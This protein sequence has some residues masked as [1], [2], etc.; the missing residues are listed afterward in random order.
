MCAPLI[1]L[2]KKFQYYIS[3]FYSDVNDSSIFDCFT[4]PL[5]RAAAASGPERQLR[6][7]FFCTHFW[8]RFLSISFRADPHWWS[9]RL[10]PQDAVPPE[11]CFT[12]RGVLG[13]PF[14]SLSSCRHV[15][16]MS[17]FKCDLV[18]AAVWL[19]SLCLW[20]VCCSRVWIGSFHHNWG[21]FSHYFFQYFY[22]LILNVLCIIN[23]LLGA[24]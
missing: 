21:I 15:V 9:F 24:Q 11:G 16:A 20:C 5:W 14:S 18:V 2:Y 8:P 1:F 22:A 12:G 19:S 10:C 7:R 6:L 23:I 3:T 17:G 13:Q 4:A